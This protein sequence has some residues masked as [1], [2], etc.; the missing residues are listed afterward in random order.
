MRLDE[1]QDPF[2]RVLN[3]LENTLTA[4]HIAAFPVRCWSRADHVTKVREEIAK[5]HLDFS[6]APIRDDKG[7]IRWIACR[8]DLNEKHGLL[9]KHARR[10]EE[11]HVVDANHPLRGTLRLLRDHGILLVRSPE[12]GHPDGISG[13]INH[14]DI[15]KTP[16]RML[17]FAQITEIEARLRN[18]ASLELWEEN[19]D[20]AA[21]VVLAKK[22]RGNDP[23]LWLP[24][25][26]YLNLGRLMCLTRTCLP[27]FLG[28]IECCEFLECAKK[29]TALRNAI[30]HTDDI[31]C[32]EFL[33]CAKK[34]TALRNA[35]A[36]TD[37]IGCRRGASPLETI[38]AV[39]SAFDLVDN[40]LKALMCLDKTDGS[41]LPSRSYQ[42]SS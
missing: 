2:I 23:E 21:F 17:L 11:R 27:T 9:V 38:A 1:L 34:L 36:H 25:I 29:L 18:R 6:H 39:N 19:P 13:I 5:D 15:Q 32:R 4:S 12:S 30:A 8:E 42:V 28:E 10:L 14:A 26:N 35:I 33:K 41:A 22:R 37:D 16:V 31:G 7:Y 24:L 40:I 20:C 3:H